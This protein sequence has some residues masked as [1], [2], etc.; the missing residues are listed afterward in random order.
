M[1]EQ[2]QIAVQGAVA[3]SE[4]GTLLDQIMQ[5]TNM[6]TGDEA[7]DVASKGVQAF[8]AEI[9]KSGEKSDRIRKQ[10]VD[11][12]IASIDEK[13]SLQVDQILHEDNFQKM[14]SAW[15]GLKFV[16]DRTD[17]R[18]NNRIQLLNVSK[19]DLAMDFEDA[20][21]IT[22]SGLYKKIYTAEFGQHGGEPVS[23]MIANYEFDHSS[24]DISL[25]Q[26]V[27]SIATMSHAP[28]IAAAAPEFFGVDDIQKLPNLND[29]ASIFEG[30]QYAKWRSFRDSED[31]R[32][33]GLTMPRFL[34][35]LPYDER[36]NPVKAFKYNESISGDH[37]NYLWGNTSFSF[38]SRLTESFAKYRWCPNIIGPQSGGAVEDLPLHQYEA[39][40]Q[41]E[42]KI[43]TEV[44]VSDRREF[45][46]AE[47]GFIPLTFRK[48]SDNAAFFSANSTQ[49]PKF[50]GVSKEGKQA[51]MNYK[52]STQLPY[53]FIVNRL[54]HYIKVLQRENIGSWKERNDLE[55]ELNVWIRQF[56]ANQDGASADV[57]SKRPLREASIQ[58]ADVEGEPGFYKVSL[59]VRPHFKYMGADFTLSLVGKLDK[60]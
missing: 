31:A 36:D 39:M 3:V 46:L 13:L 57:R 49:K 44:L 12:M 45:E 4:E 55:E 42:T 56:V 16:V 10:L 43:P 25:M 9:L 11:E 48:G 33:L 50:F 30:P 37:Q 18:E 24:P 60:T 17:F 41:I 40:G 2:E 6:K 53:M 5:Q 15:R 58:V 52:L 54:A 1:S 32:S 26:S 38:A 14:E 59:H 27:A 19:E 35:R 23:A 20:S 47:A 34:L 21:D 7:Y 51:E 8:I 29:I 28:F 22:E